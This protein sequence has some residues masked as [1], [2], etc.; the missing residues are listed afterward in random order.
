MTTMAKTRPNEID[1]RKRSVAGLPAVRWLFNRLNRRLTQTFHQ[2]IIKLNFIMLLLGRTDFFQLP[3][4]ITYS[5]RG[6]G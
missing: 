5:A 3:P 4:D 1:S 2:K 6:Q